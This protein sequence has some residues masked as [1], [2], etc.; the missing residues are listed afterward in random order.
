MAGDCAK[1]DRCSHK[2]PEPRARATQINAS[3]K[4]HWTTLTAAL[5]DFAGAFSG[6]SNPV[7]RKKMLS[8]DNW[9]LARGSWQIPDR[10][11]GW[12]APF[13]APM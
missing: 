12:T 10:R 2:N 6:K 3:I 8:F 4:I 7:Y 13:S 11:Q 9:T 1:R 5:E